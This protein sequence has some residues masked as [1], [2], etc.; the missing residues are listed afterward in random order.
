M[1]RDQLKKSTKTDRV[2]WLPLAAL[3]GAAVVL[4]LLPALY[5][6][7]ALVF[8]DR[9]EPVVWESTIVLT[10][11]PVAPGAEVRVRYSGHRLR[12]CDGVARDH[13]VSP[14]GERLYSLEAPIGYSPVGDFSAV[15]TWTVP[16]TAQSGLHRIV[17]RLAHSCEDGLHNAFHP[18]DA[19]I[20]VRAPT[21]LP[22]NRPITPPNLNLNPNQEEDP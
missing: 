15:V 12:H 9:S 4:L 18:A 3:G 2:L 10:P 7:W 20:T 11:Q 21:T 16:E 19:L 13:W 1:V 14:E 8:A 17:S 22:T 6:G 5:K